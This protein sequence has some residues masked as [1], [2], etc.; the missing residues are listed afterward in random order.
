MEQQKII[1]ELDYFRAQ[2][3]TE[4]LYTQRLISFVEYDKL[5][6]LNRQTFSPL[7]SDLFPKTLEKSSI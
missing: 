7:Y 5:T 2:A 6:E 4:L 1:D 3:I